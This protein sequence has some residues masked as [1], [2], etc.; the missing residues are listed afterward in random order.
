MI[1]RGKNM[2]YCLCVKPNDKNLLHIVARQDLRRGFHT[3]FRIVATATDE[4]EAFELVA[5]LVQ[6]YCDARGCLDFSGFKQ[7]AAEAKR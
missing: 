2:E 4:L 6:D 5:A 7:W 3:P 1:K